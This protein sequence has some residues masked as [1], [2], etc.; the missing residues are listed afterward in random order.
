MEAVQTLSLVEIARAKLHHLPDGRF[1]NPWLPYE[2]PK[3]A[4]IIKWKLSHLIVKE[5]PR[6]PIVKLMK[7]LLTSTQ[8]PLVCF[9]GH[10]TV[11]VRLEGFNF[12]FDP[13]FGNI[14][15]IVK[16]HTLPPLL[17]EELPEIDFVLYSH[18]HRDHLDLPSFRKIPG[19]PCVV[20]PLNTSLYIRHESLIEL[21]WFETYET[22]TFAIT[23]VPLQ[24]WSKRNLTDTNFALWAGFILKS[25]GFTLFFGGDTGYFFGFEEIGKL[26]GP[27]DLA[28]LPAGAYLPRELMAPFHLSPEEAVKAACELKTRF[29]MPIHWGAY[30][31]GDE[32]LDDPPKKFKKCALNSE[33]KAL[34]SYP[35]EVV[36][37]EGKTPLFLTPQLSF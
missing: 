17:P 20:A 37:F 16:R 32:A 22:D 2:A 28:L 30:K 12:L 14:V 8:G 13:I 19:N 1:K 29:A 27:F 11:F 26:F 9:L 23:A 25:R 6:I 36:S 35:G 15:G 33:L 34:I 18:A 21:D 3:L 24:H 7:D 5:T 10:D 31:L 4:K